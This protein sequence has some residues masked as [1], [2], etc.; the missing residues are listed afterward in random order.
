MEYKFNNIKEDININTFKS[1]SINLIKHIDKIV[2][3]KEKPDMISLAFDIMFNE[4]IV[5]EKLDY[6]TIN[7]KGLL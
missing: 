1:Y 4:R 7:N 6:Q 5:F 2:Q 3:Q